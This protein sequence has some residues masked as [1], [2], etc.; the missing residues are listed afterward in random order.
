M[1]LHFFINMMSNYNINIIVDRFGLDLDLFSRFKASPYNKIY[2]FADS[3]E[4]LTGV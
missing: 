4:L 1:L 2:E 3:G